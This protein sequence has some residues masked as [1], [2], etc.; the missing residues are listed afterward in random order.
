MH[1]I[2]QDRAARTEKCWKVRSF[3]DPPL[4]K[5]M[6]QHYWIVLG[7]ATL[8]P[9]VHAAPVP[10]EGGPSRIDFQR[11]IRPVLAEYCFRCH[12]PDEGTR[13][14]NLRLDTKEGAFAARGGRRVLVPGRAEESELVR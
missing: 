7:L 11:H 6:K 8:T 14:A 5:P 10:A 12:G 13:V 1:R 9:T 2:K 4:T 3:S